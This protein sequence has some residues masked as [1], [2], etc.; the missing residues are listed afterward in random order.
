MISKGQVDRRQR[1]SRTEQPAPPRRLQLGDEIGRIGQCSG[2]IGAT[3][4]CQ[5]RQGCRRGAAEQAIGVQVGGRD[6]R[7]GHTHQAV[8]VFVT[9][10]HEDR[11]VEHQ[12]ELHDAFDGVPPADLRPVLDHPERQVCPAVLDVLAMDDDVLGAHQQV[13]ADG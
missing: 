6:D 10:G 2:A 12:H 7:P 11:A 3:S 5:R 13:G 9:V 4:R 1:G 8:R